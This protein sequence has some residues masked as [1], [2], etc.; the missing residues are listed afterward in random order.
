L[1]YAHFTHNFSFS[2]KK[3]HYF[4]KKDSPETGFSTDYGAI[5]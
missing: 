5:W 4:R 2:C 3:L 1:L